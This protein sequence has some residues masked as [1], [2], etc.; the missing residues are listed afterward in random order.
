MNLLNK[1]KNK[2]SIRT[3]VICKKKLPKNEFLR[4][5]RN[6]ESKVFFDMTKKAQGRGMSICPNFSCASKLN[7]K[8]IKNHLNI[9]IEDDDWENILK[10]IQ[11]Q[12]S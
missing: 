10:Q 8:I 2:I 11:S 3:C 7:K 12:K 9:E 4:I 1:K 6:L 5:V